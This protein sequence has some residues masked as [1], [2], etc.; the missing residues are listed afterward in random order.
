MRRRSQGR[1]QLY[2]QRGNHA[3]R[4]PIKS[5]VREPCTDAPE[6]TI[7]VDGNAT[8]HHVEIP[9]DKKDVVYHYSVRSGSMS[10]LVRTFKGLPALEFRVA[11]AAN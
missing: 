9:I 1:G 6:Q 5:T 11:V 7:S 4:I 10:S 8:P 2:K 3:K